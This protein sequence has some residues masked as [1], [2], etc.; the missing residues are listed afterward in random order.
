[1][2]TIGC[3]RS[4]EFYES[5]M[6]MLAAKKCFKDALA[7]NDRL[8]RDGLTPST[9]TQSCLVSF[10]AELGLDDKSV[11]FFERLCE[12]GPPSIRACM[13]VLRV[14]FKRK[15]WAASVAHLRLM[16]EKGVEAD[17]IC[18][19]IALATGVAADRVHE[20]KAFLSEAS[21]LRVSD[22]ISFN[23]I[24]KGLAQKGLID[25]ASSL[26]AAMEKQGVQANIVTY[27]TMIDCAVRARMNDEVWRLYGEMRQR[28]SL[29]PDKCTCSTLVKALQQR[30][31]PEQLQ[32]VLELAD[33]VV[34]SCQSD[35][36]GRLLGGILD[37]ALRS[38]DLRLALRAKDKFLEKGFSLSEADARSIAQLQKR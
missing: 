9:V 14:H 28:T 11:H 19:N 34:E 8:E 2:E 30:P 31:T 6:R 20:A 10:S 7:M 21:V 22:V 4:V 27:N 25:D 16:L 5:A 12:T 37:A 18:L 17:C 35:L 23:T 13:V 1:M 3:A 24:L 15:D 33:D 29:K 26:F 36:A 32:S 38:S